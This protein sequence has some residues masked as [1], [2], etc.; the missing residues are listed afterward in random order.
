MCDAD[1]KPWNELP[2]L[3]DQ[4]WYIDC[5]LDEAMRRV[6]NRQIRQGLSPAV[7]NRRIQT[8]D[9]PNAELVATCAEQCDL[10]VP[11]LPFRYGGQN[12]K[13]Q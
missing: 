5:N 7:S 8:N 4:T 9:R 13:R 12:H 10:L 3:F 6:R 2:S 11:S 1:I